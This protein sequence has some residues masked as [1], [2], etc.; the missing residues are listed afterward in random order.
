MADDLQQAAAGVQEHIKGAEL[1]EN[2]VLAAYIRREGAQARG[3]TWSLAKHFRRQG[4]SFEAAA[5]GAVL[6]IGGAETGGDRAATDE[7]IS[8]HR[9]DLASEPGAR[10]PDPQALEGPPIEPLSWYPKR[11][12]PGDIDGDGAKKLLGTPNIPLASVLVRETA[13]N[14]WDARTFESDVDFVINMRLL[15]PEATDTLRDICFPETAADVDI[16]ESMEE[17]IWALEISDR[18]TVGLRGPTRNDL[19]VPDGTPT[20]FVDLVFNLGGKH[21]VAASGG[22]YGFGKTVAYKAS[23][24]GTVLMWSRVHTETGI[25]D[26][27]IGS[28]I[29]DRFDMGGYRYTGRHWWGRMIDGHIQPLIGPA[30]SRLGA[31]V[32]NK[33]FVGG[34]TGTSILILCPDLGSKSPDRDVPLLAEAVRWHLWP[35]RLE[36]REGDVRM[37]IDIQLQG[38]SLQVF[39]EGLTNPHLDS[40]N[41]C[42][43]SVRAVQDGEDV[44]DA[45][46]PVLVEE[47]WC[48]R[49][50][51]LLGHLALQR[52]QHRTID[53]FAEDIVPIEEPARHV[54]LMRNSAELVVK[55]LPA[56]PLG[57]PGFRWMGV[58][59]PVTALDPVFASS[60][61]PAHDDW[62]PD[63]ADDRWGK[64]QVRVGLRR[65]REIADNFAQP[66]GLPD[67]QPGS[68]GSVA[69]IADA[70]ADLVPTV[71]AS[72]PEPRP[73]RP[74][75]PGSRKPRVDVT[76]QAMGPVDEHGDR[77]VALELLVS[78]ADLPATLVARGSIGVDGGSDSGGGDVEVI[79]W[80]AERP[81]LE[82]VSRQGAAAT[83]FA[84]QTGACWVLVRAKVDLAV[85]IQVDVVA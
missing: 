77:L 39:P 42:L 25:E 53:T 75:A 4:Y 17:P 35:K 79:G 65:I 19:S 21:E 72:R 11:Y 45:F 41:A 54:A 20:N 70:L 6:G 83:T 62:V 12:S 64:T 60:E 2:T 69:A 49:P 47:V 13:Q 73:S 76:G 18:G 44:P 50:L 63:G 38:S 67:L 24:L 3:D 30:A 48:Q 56:L 1:N 68:R 22:T 66:I 28:S 51:T 58:F 10:E 43:R 61:P 80:S 46:P 31:A 34:E 32:F 85:D 59:K 36:A 23:R 71:S 74:S 16:V 57:E 8:L 55:Y 29:G 15:S 26:R 7:V 52:Y 78:D 27:I 33:G 5:R 9:L 40:L 84:S 81:D 82:L 37:N 14:A